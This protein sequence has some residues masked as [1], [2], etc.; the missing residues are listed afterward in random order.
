MDRKDLPGIAA[1]IIQQ[2]PDW[3]DADD[4]RVEPLEGL[5]NTNYAVIVDDERF[6]LRIGGQ[7]ASRLGID[8]NQEMVTLKAV[9]DAGIGAQVVFDKLPEGHLVTRTIQGRH[10]PLEEYRKSENIERI[11]RAVKRLHAL[12]LDHAAFSPFRR[13]ENYAAQAREMGVPSPKDYQQLL[14]K[15]NAIEQE[16]ARDP[17]P[18]QRFCH[19]DLFCVNV[20]DDGEIRF[21]DWEFSG[22]N[23][24]YF[25][26]AT[27]TYAYDSLDTLPRDL[28]EHLL[29]LYFGEVRQEN[30][31]RLEGMQ[32]ILM[33]F[34]AMW[35]L[36]QQGL[37]NEGLVRSVDGF[38]FMEYSNGTFEAMRRFL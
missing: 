31:K 23:D 37:Y 22:V 28:Q 18:W 16:Q 14:V 10:L 17:F 19:N 12:P 1:E 32:Y 9:S 36:M 25:D 11:V 6:V 21:I 5:T 26:L 20:L 3:E 7:N 38:D 2:V 35:G 15:M 24:I 27:L 13:V 29:A 8:R 30:W 34:T 4:I 33:F